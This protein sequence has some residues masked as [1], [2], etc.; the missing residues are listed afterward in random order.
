MN[1]EKNIMKKWWEKYGWLL[2]VEIGGGVYF[3]IRK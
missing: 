2:G 1:M 3:V